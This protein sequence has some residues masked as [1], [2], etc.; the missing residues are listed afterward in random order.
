VPFY[1]FEAL[2][3]AGKR[4][5]GSFQADN[6]EEIVR[7]LRER[8]FQPVSVDG[9]RV[10]A[11][12]SV[13]G[14]DP[15][16]SVVPP[17]IQNSGPATRIVSNSVSA[18][19]SASTA[20]PASSVVTDVPTASIMRQ[21][22]QYVQWADL[23]RTGFSQNQIIHHLTQGR[24]QSNFSFFSGFDGMMNFFALAFN[25]V[26]WSFLAYAAV[27]D[28]SK[29]I[30]VMFEE[31]EQATAGGAP[32]SG[33]M[34]KRPFQFSPWI[35]S[36][37]RIGELSGTLPEAYDCVAVTV[38]RASA[39]ISTQICVFASLPLVT[40]LAGLSLA[41][42]RGSA[43]AIRAHSDGIAQQLANEGD[44]EFGKRILIEET[45]KNIHLFWTGLA[46][47]SIIFLVSVIL[48]HPSLRLTR[49]FLGLMVPV[50]YP[51]AKAEAVERLSWSVHQALRAGQSPA[52]T[53]HL[54]VQTIPNLYLRKV[55][56]E[57]VGLVREHDS[58]PELMIRTKL[59]SP[60]Y[61]SII[62]TGQMSGT[63]DRSLQQI[64]KI[65]G[66]NAD[67]LTVVAKVLNYILLGVLMGAI[68]GIIIGMQYVSYVNNLVEMMKV[69]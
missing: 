30:R 26:A 65:E 51:R 5:S 41:L 54:A 9:V 1:K 37:V 12:V 24:I 53:M 14:P 16:A 13:S 23:T 4:I 35:A 57:R 32:V 33:E 68:F 43:Q 46:I 40:A 58:L 6:P 28:R 8:G 38:K 59:F 25:P 15:V 60:E 50:C 22:F 11:S 31:M 62:Q 36:T 63:G 20:T 67:R 18:T 69:E 10:G 3:V 56:M 64:M 2:D 19:A 17:V 42:S 44:T 66:Q 55:V 7:V 48:M 49:H 21:Y 52:S 61:I 27:H 34:E 29:N 47:G 45:L 39:F